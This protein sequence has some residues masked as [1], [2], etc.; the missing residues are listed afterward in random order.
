MMISTP[1]TRLKWLCWQL[2]VLRTVVKFL[3]AIKTELFSIKKIYF[4]FNSI[5][6]FI[7][8][9]YKCSCCSSTWWSFK[10]STLVKSVLL[11]HGSIAKMNKSNTKKNKL[12]VVLCIKQLFR[13]PFFLS[14]F[15]LRYNL[16]YLMGL[17]GLI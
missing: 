13:F 14:L 15:L 11:K 1:F 8:F 2:C 6:L 3:L 12:N 7:E 10:W 17:S 9:A 4:I 16:N 5:F